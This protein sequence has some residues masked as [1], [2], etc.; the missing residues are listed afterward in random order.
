MEIR[1]ED[2]MLR[3]KSES[4]AKAS[5]FGKNSKVQLF[6][7]KNWTKGKWRSEAVHVRLAGN[8]QWERA[9]VKCLSIPGVGVAGIT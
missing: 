9:A 2:E 6:N 5:F 3:Q 1:R 4:D 8:M 7:G